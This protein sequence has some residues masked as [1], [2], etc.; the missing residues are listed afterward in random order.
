MKLS[1]LLEK[2]TTRKMQ[3]K[4]KLIHAKVNH[5]PFSLLNFL[6]PNFLKPKMTNA[7]GIKKVRPFPANVAIIPKIVLIGSPA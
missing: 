1:T 6:S 7:A 2:N 3:P 5:L 4:P